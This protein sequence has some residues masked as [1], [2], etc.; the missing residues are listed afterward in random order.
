[1]YIPRPSNN[2][3]LTLFEYSVRKAILR[4]IMDET[5][6]HAAWANLIFDYEKD[7]NM[8]SYLM[9]IV[10]HEYSYYFSEDL[11][12][13]FLEENIEA[14]FPYLFG[15]EE[16]QELFDRMIQ[17]LKAE[18]DAQKDPRNQKRYKVFSCTNISVQ[19]G[20]YVYKAQ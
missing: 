19:D 9:S 2:K 20:Q 10:K 1:M 7:A 5:Y 11:Q 3:P 16:K 4:G 18:C 15:I 14:N 17:A 13:R 6:T 12:Y 8:R